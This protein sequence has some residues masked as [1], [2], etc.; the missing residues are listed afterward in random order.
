MRVHG[1]A[2]R[3]GCLRRA[4]ARALVLVA[5]LGLVPSARSAPAPAPAPAPLEEAMARAA[6]AWLESLPR[7]EEGHLRFAAPER[8]DWHYVPRARRGV[9]LGR[10]APPQ[11]ERALALLRAGLSARGAAQAEAVMALEA[12]LAQAEGSSPAHR[13]PGNYALGVFGQPGV[14]PW[15]WR[16]EGHHL[17]LHVTVSA[18]GRVAFTPC[19]VGSNPARIPAGPRAGERVQAAEVDL[20]RALARS[21]DDAQWRTALLQ[22]RSLGDVITGP[23]R[24]A[25]LAAPQGLP[26]TALAPAQQAQALQLIEVYVGR[27]HDAWGRAYLDLVRE[28]LPQT[29][30]AWAGGRA[31]GEAF[32]YR[33]HG[34]RLLIECDNTQNRA[35]H[36]HSLWRDPQ[37]DF[38]R[39]DLR[40]HLGEAHSAPLA[41][42]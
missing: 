37:N 42:R 39:D 15:G 23:G 11:R 8:A 6:R 7:P 25:S 19:F 33:V 3:T 1:P 32:Y 24:A 16:L 35:N 30:L 38:G 5:L 17:S 22:P 12:V 20:A 21:L 40:R 9:P 18:P 27:A 41:G 31:D 14:P 13:D 36:V 29:R 10:M 2:G 4:P 26:W 28:G 34:P